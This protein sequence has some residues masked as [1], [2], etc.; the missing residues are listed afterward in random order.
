MSEVVVLLFITALL[1]VG[2]LAVWQ[3]IRGAAPRR[4]V[5]AGRTAVLFISM[6]IGVFY[7]AWRLSKS[8]TF[9]FFGHMVARVETTDRVVALTFDDGPT[10][11]RTEA[12]ITLLAEH[13]IPATFY[14]NGQ[15]IEAS[16]ES[17][18][19]LVEAGHE[20]G[21]HSYSHPQMIF[22]SM[23]FVREEFESTDALIRECGYTGDIHTRSPFGKRL[24]VYP[25]YLAATDRLNIFF[26]VEPE[27]YKEIAAD[28][29]L[30]VEN[31]LENTR[32]GSIILLH[33]MYGD[34]EQTFAAIPRIIESL[35]AQGYRF[36]T[37]SD[38]LTRLE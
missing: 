21:N 30:I 36:V 28:A 18:R 2:G 13:D 15:A 10:P 35:Q 23:R 14:L 27:S 31:V 3:A 7:G 9:Q 4:A 19:A 22:V 33:V 16:M 1:T 12:I 32:P 8:R 24:L 26:D 37:V 17:C 11:E 38:L 34:R 5:L 25:Y 20:I 29:D 6:F